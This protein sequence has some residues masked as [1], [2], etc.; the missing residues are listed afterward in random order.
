METV[1]NRRGYPLNM[2][3]GG[4]HQHSTSSDRDSQECYVFDAAKALCEIRAGST[5]VSTVFK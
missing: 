4:V 5:Q 1:W 3:I 2:Q